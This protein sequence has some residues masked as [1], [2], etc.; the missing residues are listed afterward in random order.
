MIK[1]FFFVS[2]LMLLQTYSLYAQNY[3]ASLIPDSLKEH[4]N[5]VIRL[6]DEK[7]TIKSDNR[8]ILKE[9][10]VVTILNEDGEKFAAYDNNYDK[11]V[12]LN[13]I[14]GS[15]YDAEGKKIKS[16]KKKDISDVS[17]SDDETFLTDVREKHFQFYWRTYPYTVEFEDEQDFNGIFFLP[18]WAPFESQKVS[19][20]E[21]NFI[22]E[23]PSN[24]ELRYKQ[25]NYNGAA[26]INAGKT[27]YTW[28][29]HNAKAYLFEPLQPDPNELL[30]SVYV[31]PVNFEIAGYKGSMDT[32]TD[33]G[34][35]IVQLNKDRDVLPEQ[36]RQF[37][38]NLTDTLKTKDEKVKKLYE[39]LQK[40][41]RYISVQLGIGS[42][43]PF[44][45]K[46][47]DQRKY[48]DCKA[49]SNY[50]VS[51]LKEAG[52]KANYVLINS[53]WAKRG[54]WEDFPAPYF[55]HV[56]VC[57]PNE[58]DSIWL[59]CTSQTVSPGY[60][61]TFTGDRKALLIDDDGGH[62]VST[63][64]YNAFDNLQLRKV[65]AS[66]DESGNLNADVYTTFT[67]CQQELQHGLLH[68]VSE[69]ERNE[70]LNNALNLPTYNVDKI[71][72]QELR[73][74]LPSMKE[75]LKIQSPGYAS[76]SGKRLFI[77]PNLFNK[78][79]KLENDKPRKFDVVFRNAF[80]DVDTITIK[81]PQGYTVEAKPKNVNIENKFG[82]YSIDYTILDASIEVIRVH[83]H[84]KA[85]FQATD[86]DDLVKFY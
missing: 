6:Y 57:V 33:L 56:I 8:A 61:G 80:R 55:N 49:L 19:V 39:Y 71:D 27:L 74:K 84:A 86:Y 5:A 53:G 66:I 22:V 16:I 35:F 81:L 75:Y 11:L 60:M 82:K 50:M 32:W 40:N 77:Q 3:K 34:K 51:L 47:V 20:Q 13:D 42:W 52:I 12:S 18:H 15:L 36:T 29:I 46:Y 44:E 58:K 23:T 83:E 85:R 59:E 7:L 37:V 4:A 41:T 70:Y 10:Y 54:L 79:A 26:I 24:Y 31:A 72:Y 1:R 63:P 68:D 45:A 43:Q 30:P 67:G 28:A 62:I 64:S 2:A 76:V 69:K 65:N 48:G 21:S 78:E 73:G 38:H 25:F 17:A 9:H 14:S